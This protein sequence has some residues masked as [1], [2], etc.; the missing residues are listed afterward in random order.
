MRKLV[1]DIIATFG[2]L[3]IAIPLIICI[4]LLLIFDTL[5]TKGD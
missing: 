3:V 5:I 2:T 4:G 1:L